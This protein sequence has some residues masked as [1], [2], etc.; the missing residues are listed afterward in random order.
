MSVDAEFSNGPFILT[1]EKLSEVGNSAVA[2]ENAS[3]CGAVVLTK[4]T[5]SC[6]SDKGQM[7]HDTASEITGIEEVSGE[8]G[9]L[10][11]GND[12]EKLSHGSAEPAIAGNC[13]DKLQSDQI[14]KTEI[15]DTDGGQGTLSMVAE[16][17]GVN[18]FSCDVNLVCEESADAEKVE[19]NGQKAPITE[20]KTVEEIMGKSNGSR[21]DDKSVDAENG[22]I[23]SSMAVNP[24]TETASTEEMR[25][26]SSGPHRNND[27][28]RL[29]AESADTEKVEIDGQREPSTVTKIKAVEEIIGESNGLSKNDKSVDDEKGDINSSMAINPGSEDSNSHSAPNM[30]TKIDGS[31]ETG[32]DTN[33]DVKL[34]EGSAETVKVEINGQREP[35]TVTKIEEIRSECNGSSKINES[36]DAEKSGSNNSVATDIISEISGLEGQS[37]GVEKINGQSTGVEKINIIPEISGIVVESNDAEEVSNDKL[38]HQESTNIE[39]ADSQGHKVSNVVSEIKGM[40]DIEGESD[41]TNR[42]TDG[43]STSEDIKD[44]EVADGSTQVHKG[45]ILCSIDAVASGKE[46]VNCLN[47][48]VQSVRNTVFD[49]KCNEETGSKFDG[50]K[51][52]DDKAM[53]QR[54]EDSERL[55]SDGLASEGMS[56]DAELSH[57]PSVLA[58]ARLS[59][60]ENSST[61]IS[62]DISSN[63][64]IALGSEAC[65]CCISHGQSS[66]DMIQESIGTAV[67][68]ESND[69]DGSSDDK[70]MHKNFEDGKSFNSSSQAVEGMSCNAEFSQGLSTSVGSKIS[71]VGNYCASSSKDVSSND[72]VGAENETLN[73]STDDSQ[74]L[75]ANLVREGSGFENLEDELNGGGE[76]IN[77]GI[78]HKKCEDPEN[79]HNGSDNAGAHRDAEFSIDQSVLADLKLC[80]DG[81]SSASSIKDECHDAVCGN[82]LN[83][84]IHECK[85]VPNMAIDFIDIK[86]EGESSVADQTSDDKEGESSVADQTSDDKFIRES[87]DA[88]EPPSINIDE[89]MSCDNE[90]CDDQATLADLELTEGGNTSS[91]RDVSSHDAVISENETLTCPIEIDPE[92]ANMNIEITGSEEMTGG[93]DWSNDDKLVCEQS[94]DA[95]ISNTNEA[96][97]TSAECSSVDVAAARDMNG[98]AAKGFYFLIRMP[99]FDDEKIR[100]H[101]KVAELNVDEKTQHRDAFRQKIR[102]KRANCQTHGA[103]FEAAKAQER[104]A[105]KQVRTKRADISTLQ[106]IIDKAKNAVAIGEIDN[107]ISNMEHIIGHETVP[108]KEEK[109]LIR[110]IKQLKQ[111]RG[112][113]SSNTGSQDEVQKSLDEREVNE[114]RLRVLKKELDNLKV[115]V[116]KAE[117]I[118]MTASCKFE[119]ESRKLKELQAQFKAADDIRQEAYE[120]LRNLKKGLYEKNVHFRTYKDDATLANDHARKGEM[121]ALNHLCVNQVERYMELWNNNDEF[122]KDYIRCNT[123]S[124]VRRFGTLDGRTLGPDE[125]PTV[126]PSYRVVERV[127]RLVTSVDKVNSVLQAPVPHQEKQVV[128]LKDKLKDDNIVPQA[129]EGMNQVEKTKEARK[130]TPRERITV[131]EPKETEHLQT[132][133]ELE[134]ARKEEELRKR[135][136]A[137]RLKEQRRLEE[138]A[139]AKEAL[140]RKKRNAEKAQLRAELRAQKEEEQRLKDKEKRLR[141]RERKKGSASETHSENNDGEITLISTSTRGIVRE[142]EVGESS[143]QSITKKTQKPSQYTKQMKTKA[144]PPP[145]RNRGRRRWQ[146][147]FWMVLSC[148]AVVGVFFLGNIGF[149]SHL[150]KPRNPGY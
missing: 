30:I 3:S 117:T 51:D 27:D 133:Q 96:L 34:C 141:K 76:S 91:S 43:N 24:V 13:G 40:E 15:A 130:S 132:A 71:E 113:L 83:E 148:V 1:D 149:F 89:R 32:G 143:S 93:S 94:G 35:S 64:A 124:T 110:E 140:E 10:D 63:E 129:A 137:A 16:I 19:S 138:I 122:R 67:G 111:L 98:I 144:I 92:P 70:L 54:N 146:Q 88:E 28:R 39:K 125:Q 86:K 57:G 61:S 36:E 101:I 41:A 31:N 115:K 26:K 131:D 11:K 100:E 38:V 49:T 69:V 107:R 17:K 80:E 47:D 90:I 123:R 106:D 66:A 126:L 9:G 44:G 5:S 7:E 72:D 18:E 118:A 65:N 147:W 58:D 82:T 87:G 75:G 6:P 46:S 77:N 142:F 102:N 50:D 78:P 81:N 120:E 136:E 42:R 108:L 112:Q 74:L 45:E 4:E 139:K 37:N 105:R 60:V 134:A 99:R 79:P 33:C 23:N 53:H 29:S 62:L 48:N 150:K 20:I 114:E 68:G 56:S 52:I 135:E 25:G 22:D 2:C 85:M 127:N 121:V 14:E 109:L 73:S 119:D 59:G 55:H 12:D 84:P 104:D 97:A 145:L 8:A 103:E 21:K 95:E 116:S 128:V